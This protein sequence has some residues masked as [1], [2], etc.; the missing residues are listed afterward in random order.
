MSILGHIQ[1]CNTHD[2]LRFRP[3]YIS[4]ERVGWIG[5]EVLETL[6]TLPEF[7]I[8][9]EQVTLTP[10]TFQARSAALADA[11]AQL[12]SAGLTPPLRGEL[13]GVKTRWTDPA[14]ATVDRSATAAF[15]MRSFGVHL[16]GWTQTTDG[17]ALWIGKRSMTAMVDPGKL[18]NIV[19][20]GQPHGLTLEE[21]LA[22]EAAEEADIAAALIAQ[23]KPAGAISYIM[24]TP[25]GI[26]PDVLFCYDLHVTTDFT[27]RNTDGETSGFELM[28]APIV[29]TIITETEQ[30]K[31][32][33]NLVIAQFLM[34]HGIL[35][36]DNEPDY[37]EIAA[38]L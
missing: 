18:D 7:S 4:E 11:A 8:T 24:E 30:F 29:Q 13:F 38:A 10:A 12:E 32:N 20:G 2:L 5:P 34:R 6:S 22:K 28:P 36:P 23:A 9:P 35:N 3:L 27:P 1:R 21:N 19:A 25:N 15:G 17:I 33:C 31:F 37:Q 16:N 14:L 26:R